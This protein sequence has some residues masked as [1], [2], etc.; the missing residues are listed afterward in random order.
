M[1]TFHQYVFA[2]E[3]PVCISKIAKVL[4]YKYLTK[5]KPN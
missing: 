3:Y 2:L 5:W 4:L 1:N